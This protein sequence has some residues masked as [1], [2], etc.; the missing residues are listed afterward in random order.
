MTDQDD[1]PSVTDHPDSDPAAPL[2][3]RCAEAVEIVTDFLDDALS[4]HDLAVFEAHLADCEGCTIFVDQISMTIRLTSESGKRDV[5][6]MPANFDRLL[7]QLRR[8]ADD[9]P[10]G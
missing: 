6:V 1:T 2:H 3:L 7:E 5:D 10:P 9:A 8:R 4:E